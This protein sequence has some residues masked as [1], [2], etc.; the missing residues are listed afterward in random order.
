MTVGPWGQPWGQPEEPPGPTRAALVAAVVTL[1]ALGVSWLA[2]TPDFSF[3][4][5]ARPSPVDAPPVPTRPFAV[6]V[7]ERVAIVVGPLGEGERLVRTEPVGTEIRRL[8][9]L[10][11]NGDMPGAVDHLL[12]ATVRMGTGPERALL[13]E[14]AREAVAGRSNVTAESVGRFEDVI[15]RL[16]ADADA[17][18]P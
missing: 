4:L 10:L 14:R 7:A 8:N 13:L 16:E 9:R 6:V 11:T 2:A 17:D 12:A 1:V 5:S 15:A 3:E 18:G